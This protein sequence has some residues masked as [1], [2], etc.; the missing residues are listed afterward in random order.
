MS[1]LVGLSGSLVLLLSLSGWSPPLALRSMSPC[2]AS[3]I[4]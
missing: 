3:G 4:G 2:S 1:K